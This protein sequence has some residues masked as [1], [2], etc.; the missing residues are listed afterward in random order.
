MG[1]PR[2]IGPEIILK[3]L[4]DLLSGESHKKFIPVI[5]GDPELIVPEAE[6]YGLVI[7]EYNNRQEPE[8][9]YYKRAN[10]AG[11]S[12]QMKRI[13]KTGEAES[14]RNKHCG[15]KP[16]VVYLINCREANPQKTAL[17]CINKGVHS[18]LQNHD[19]RLVTAPVSK[20]EISKEMP[21]FTGHTEYIAKLSGCDFP[22]MSF[23]TPRLKLSLLTTHIPL[24]DV[25]SAMSPEKIVRHVK[26]VHASLKNVFGISNPRIV[27]SSVNPHAGESGHIG[28]EE[29]EVFSAAVNESK[30]TGITVEGPFGAAHALREALAG[31]FN[32]IVSPYHDQMLP[33]VKNFL[34]PSVNFTMGLPFIRLSPDH[35]PAFDMAGRDKADYA[36]MKEAVRLASIL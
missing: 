30:K 8:N 31:N 16:A 32:L 29:I 26:V 24:K 33:A 21:D 25:P 2:G 18:C 14:M 28:R 23:I 6:K 19:A 7:N 10:T 27:L 5:I 3:S 17:E 12:P 20:A 9:I 4:R 35:G 36:S 1:D 15:C 34:Q 13:M 11:V 22:V